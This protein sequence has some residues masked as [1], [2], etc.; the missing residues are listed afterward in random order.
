[1]QTGSSVAADG[2]RIYPRTGNF[3]QPSE[4]AWLAQTYGGASRDYESGF[5]HR[6]NKL[7]KSQNMPTPGEKQEN[8]PMRR[9]SMRKTVAKHVSTM[10]NKKGNVDGAEKRIVD[11]SKDDKKGARSRR[12]GLPP[13]SFDGAGDEASMDNS[14]TDNMI[15][16]CANTSFGPHS[17]M[18]ENNRPA[19]T[20]YLPSVNLNRASSSLSPPPHR[21]FTSAMSSGTSPTRFSKASYSQPSSIST[22]PSSTDWSTPSS[23]HDFRN[24]TRELRIQAIPPSNPSGAQT[25][26]DSLD[27]TKFDPV[28]LGM[29]QKPGDV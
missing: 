6:V 9:P 13:L 27:P 2:L 20:I 23:M 26:L 28:R 3:P 14:S 15:K 29:S 8:L 4:A 16:D 17:H 22:A 19:D 1:M 12:I 21:S 18:V 24:S 25:T 7:N 5:E 11:S 10:F